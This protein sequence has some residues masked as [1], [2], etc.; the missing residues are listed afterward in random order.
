MMERIGDQVPHVISVEDIIPRN[1]SVQPNEVFD[2][3][4]TSWTILQQYVGQNKQLFRN[5]TIPIQKSKD[6][7]D[8]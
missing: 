7:K 1:M 2:I 5:Y 6:T 8:Y 3:N 4:I